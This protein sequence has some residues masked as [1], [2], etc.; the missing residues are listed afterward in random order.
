M[1]NSAIL[2]ARAQAYLSHHRLNNRP[3]A[4]RVTQVA[5]PTCLSAY[6]AVTAPTPS[7]FCSFSR[8]PERDPIWPQA[9]G[10]ARPS[11]HTDPRRRPAQLSSRV[12]TYTVA[13]LR[14]TRLNERPPSTTTY[15]PPSPNKPPPSKG[16]AAEKKKKRPP[17]SF[18][19]FSFFSSPLPSS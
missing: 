12:A 10:P 15:H 2:S 9:A 1:Y 7:L 3:P 4:R 8:A 11:V 5:S 19:I 18:L 6:L 16:T 13:T 14:E 17:P